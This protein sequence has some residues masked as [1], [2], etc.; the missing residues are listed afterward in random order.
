MRP[1]S[2]PCA[3]R[4]RKPSI[5]RILLVRLDGIGDA[6]VCAPLIAAL[7]DAGHELGALLTTRNQTVFA[8]RAF[9]RVHAVERIPWPRHGATPESRA[10]ALEEIRA[11]E[12]AVALIVS[13]E[14]D[15]YLLP[16]EAGIALRIGFV[17]GFEKPLKTLRYG[18]TLSRAVLRPASRSGVREHEAETIFRL[19]AGLC[20]EARPTRDA[21]RLRPLVLDDD[22]PP[23]GKLVMQY[24]A[25]FAEAGLDAAAFAALSAALVANGEEPLCLCDD[26]AFA[27]DVVTRGGVPGV[28]AESLADWKAALAGARAVVTPDSGAAHVA[29]MLGV[30]CIALLPPLPGAPSDL[31]R[32]QPWTGPSRTLVALELAAPYAALLPEF[33]QRARAELESLP[34]PAPVS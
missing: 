24:S 2:A 22:P 8:A 4:W 17:N 9:E 32:W 27:A 21:A 16:G 34:A 6:L 20:D 14:P 23:H 15:A 1:T 5:S 31:V 12:Y 30:P 28:A 29:G 18:L 11:A 13:E 10:R 3:K 26:A 19:G 25:K 33:V 7:R